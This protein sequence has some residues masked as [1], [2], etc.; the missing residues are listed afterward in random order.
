MREAVKERFGFF[1]CTWQLKA[2]LI[3]LEQ[4]DLVT[5][6]PTGSRKTLTF[7]IPLLFN[8]DGLIIVVTPLIVLGEKN[9]GELSFRLRHNISLVSILAINLTS[10]SVLDETFKDIESLKFCV[11]ITSPERILNDRHF[12]DLWKTKTFVNKLRCIIFDEA[13]CISQWSGEFWPEYAEVGRLRWLLPKHV[14]FYGTSAT[15]PC[16]VLDHVKTILHMRPESTREIRLTSDRPNIHL[17]TLEMLDPLS[18]CHDTLCVFRFDGDPPPPPFMVFCNDRKETEH[19]FQYACLHAPAELTDKL[20]EIW[21]IFCTDTA[22]MGL[23][24]HDIQ[25][26]VQWRYMPSLCTLWQRL[27]RAV[28]DPSNEATGIYVVEPQYTDHHRKRA[29]QRAAER[30]EREKKKG[31]Q[32]ET[33]SDYKEAA[34]DTYI[35]AHSQ[36]ICR[37]KV[38]EEFFGNMPSEC[39]NLLPGCSRI[40]PH[41]ASPSLACSNEGCPCCVATV[42]GLCCDTCNPGSFILPAPTTT[43]PRQTCAHN[44]F[45]VNKSKCK[46]T[47]ADDSLTS[48]LQEWRDA[49]LTSLGFPVGDEMYGSQLIMTD[50]I[51]ECLVE[52]AHF[53]QLVD[54]ASIK[55]QVNW[56]YSDLWGTQI[57]EI[58]KKHAPSTNDA[59]QLSATSHRPRFNPLVLETSLSHPPLTNIQM[60]N[61]TR[62]PASQMLLTLT[63]SHVL[64]TAITSAVHVAALAIL[65]RPFYL[66]SMAQLNCPLASN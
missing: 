62:S 33:E 43:A 38:S 59:D 52:L 54:L 55:A 16:H 9:V 29:E 3:Q 46:M 53:N 5:L 42:S 1:P 45:K 49:Q 7:W 25:V 65:V 56:C 61:Q 27:G 11:V 19:L 57:L 44:R 26:V 36:G 24:V 14:V 18:S 58:I 28:R 34:M 23:D 60:P 6:A 4:N 64:G 15:L 13:H 35:N 10:S 50:N 17:V 8:G 21:G 63:P 47:D 32:R 40:D 2:A 66:L 41:L 30:M 20:R 12:L 37:R 39:R 48:A 22:G 51:L 31:L